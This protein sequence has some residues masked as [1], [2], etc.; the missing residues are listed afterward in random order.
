MISDHG[1]HRSLV[2]W[3]TSQEKVVGL[4]IDEALSESTTEPEFVR[5]LEHHRKWLAARINELTNR[6]A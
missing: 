6:A 3:L 4:W 2:S 1:E 5:K